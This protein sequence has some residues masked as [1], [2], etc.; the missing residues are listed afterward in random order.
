MG[1]G[2]GCPPPPTRPRPFPYPKRGGLAF[3]VAAADGLAVAERAAALLRCVELLVGQRRRARKGG[4]GGGVRS[5][6]GDRPRWGARGEPSGGPRRPRG[7]G[8][9]AHH[10]RHA[11]GSPSPAH[12]GPP[13]RPPLPLGLH[14]TPTGPQAHS[15]PGPPPGSGCTPRGAPRLFPL[16]PPLPAHPQYRVVDHPDHGLLPHR[17]PYA[18]AAEGV[19]VH[20]VGGAVEGVDLP[21]QFG[22]G[23]DRGF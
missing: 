21:V 11:T 9:R 10:P 2:A 17:Q 15:G 22:R 7:F 18:D 4:A 23:F 8:G 1:A 12:T 6:L 5:R 3:C 20:K 13:A 14:T 19:A 16:R